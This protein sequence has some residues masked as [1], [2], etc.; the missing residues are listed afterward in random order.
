MTGALLRVDLSGQD[1][2]LGMLADAVTRLSNPRPM[3]EDIGLALVT[4]THH[5]FDRSK[6]PD[7]SPWPPSLRVVQRGGKTLILSSRLYR[8]ITFDASPTQVEVGTNVIYAA[9]HQFGGDIDQAPREAVLHFKT[10]KRTGV[11][12]FAKPS[13]ADRARKATIG[14]RTIHMPA[15][16][17][18]G[19]DQDDPRTITTIVEN[20]IAGGGQL[21]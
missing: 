9:I 1:K 5:R 14:A 11:S 12:R 19:L 10:N 18:L 16:P 3:F 13:K 2:A 8:S 17:F 7:G 15:R 4:S 6:A 20:F 21:S